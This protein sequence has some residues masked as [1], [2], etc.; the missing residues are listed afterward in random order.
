MLKL[1]FKNNLLEFI[2]YG[3]LSEHS[4]TNIINGLSISPLAGVAFRQDGRFRKR[5]VYQRQLMIFYQL[6]SIHQPSEVTI[7]GYRLGKMKR[8]IGLDNEKNRQIVTDIFF[9][10]PDKQIRDKIY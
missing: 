5:A 8:P 1:R 7:I 6:N 4:R 3:L 2:F 9:N 10:Y